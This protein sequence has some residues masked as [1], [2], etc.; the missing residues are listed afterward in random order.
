MLIAAMVFV[1]VVGLGVLY[2]VYL[3]MRQQRNEKSVDPPMEEIRREEEEAKEKAKDVEQARREDLAARAKVCVVGK[4]SE[5]KKRGI[6]TS[7][8]APIVLAEGEIG[9][10][11]A[12]NEFPDATKFTGPR[13]LVTRSSS[14][15]ESDTEENDVESN[16]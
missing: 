9:G 12:E 6:I 8:W 1:G 2:G 15:S 16:V 3:L 5:V 10:F 7:L 14:A 4:D 13:R 11:K